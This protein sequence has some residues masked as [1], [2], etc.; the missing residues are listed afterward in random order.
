M[1]EMTVAE[2]KKFVNMFFSNNSA[3]AIARS[4][5]LGM[6]EAAESMA[7]DEGDVMIP[8][9]NT[10]KM[11]AT[12]YAEDFLADFKESVL[13]EIDRLVKSMMMTVDVEVKREVMIRT[14]LDW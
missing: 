11:M 4:S 9:S 7:E 6:I 2:Q 8:D 1:T 3:E 13:E 14:N 5:V 12:D 10:I